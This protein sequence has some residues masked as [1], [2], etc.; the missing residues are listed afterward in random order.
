MST[1]K[2]Q[3]G[4][5]NKGFFHSVNAALEGV[6]HTL[7]S[8]RNMRVHFLVG[9]LVV[10]T[11]IYLNFDSIEM[12]LLCFAVTFVLAAEMFNTAIEHAI[13]LINDEYHKLAK[14]SKDVAAGAVF[15]SA[16]NALITGY[17][18]FARRVMWGGD[19]LLIKVKQSPWHITLITILIVTGMVLLV[20]ILRREETLLRGGMPSG[21][22]AVAFS[23]WMSTS[24]LTGNV[25]VSILVFL[26]AF[27]VARGR[28]VNGIHNF[29]QV[30]AGGALGALVT[31]VFQVLS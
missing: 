16:V 3:R 26:L 11:G 10:I 13:D 24:L 15:V 21:H 12:M 2:K 27:L 31:F 29:G 17:F 9:F 19:N 23:V 25:L 7:K 20:K 6:V 30:L 5:F 4:F 18:L 22:S 8:E 14:I 1:Y 28:M